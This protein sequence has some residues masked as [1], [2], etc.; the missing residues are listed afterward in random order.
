[1]FKKLFCPAVLFPV[2]AF[3]SIPE[4]LVDLPLNEGDLKAIQDVSPAKAAVKIANPEFI[5]WVDGPQGKALAFSNA[6]GRVKRGC[7]L[8]KI[9]ARLDIAKGVSFAC[10]FRTGKQFAPRRIYPLFRYADGHEKTAGIFIFCSWNMVWARIGSSGKHTD[11]RTKTTMESIKPDTWYRL[12]VTSDGKTVAIY[13]NGKL[14]ASGKATPQKPKTPYL[15]IGST[16]DIYGYGFNGVISQVKVFDR[17]LNAEE[18]TAMQ[19]ED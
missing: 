15:Q 5:S 16:G 13:L 2:M 18:I 11:V 17:A 9:P 12:V 14:A 7:V 10:T 1:M 8:V 6:D 3:A 4:A 19:Q